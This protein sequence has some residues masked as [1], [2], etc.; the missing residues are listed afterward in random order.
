VKR[1]KA[2]KNIDKIKPDYGIKDK[3]YKALSIT[4]RLL[5]KF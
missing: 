3:N 5:F 4:L 2:K 1:N